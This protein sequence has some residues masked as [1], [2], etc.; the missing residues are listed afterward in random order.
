MNDKRTIIWMILFGLVRTFLARWS[1]Q[2]ES[3]LGHDVYVWLVAHGVESIVEWIIFGVPLA[4]SVLQKLQVIGW[5]KTALFMKSNAPIA[6]I[7]KN[8]PGPDMAV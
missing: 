2:L 4:W 8:A 3:V 5:L 7:V 1:A 6:D